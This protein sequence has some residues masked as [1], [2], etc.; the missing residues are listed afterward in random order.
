MPQVGFELATPVFERVKTVH[1]LDR[2]A[3]VIGFLLSVFQNMFRREHA[4]MFY[5][6]VFYVQRCM[7]IFLQGLH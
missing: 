1:V 7:K 3:A 5:P 2:A 4:S 6:Y